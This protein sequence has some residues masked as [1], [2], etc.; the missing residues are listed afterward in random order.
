MADCKTCAQCKADATQPKASLVPITDHEYTMQFATI[1][2]A[3]VI[4]DGEGFQYLLLIGCIFSK[5]IE[6]VPLH[7]QTAPT[8]VKA[9]WDNWIT[10]PQYIA[11]SRK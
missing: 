10:I 11:Q 5:F 2:V 4:S 3:H 8:L 1:D 9:I 6:A 7:D